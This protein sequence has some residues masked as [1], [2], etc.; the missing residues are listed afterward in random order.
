ME[1][2]K[3]GTSTDATIA[4]IEGELHQWGW[5]VCRLGD[6]Y[7]AHLWANENVGPDA[8]RQVFAEA[9]TPV[10]ALNAAL[11]RAKRG[12]FYKGPQTGS[13]ATRLKKKKPR[14]A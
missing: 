5:G 13:I 2:K 8:G 10:A 4:R 9:D 1:A 3:I 11:D 6:K 14:R 7:Q 12:E